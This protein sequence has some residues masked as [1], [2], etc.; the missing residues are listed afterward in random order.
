MSYA[1]VVLHEIGCKYH[2]TP[3]MMN[4]SMGRL[5]GIDAATFPPLVSFHPG[6]A[7]PRER[8]PKCAR[9]RNHGI[10]SWLKGH[11][12]HCKY[13]T[14]VCDKCKLIAERQRVMAA[15]VALK[16]KQAA[17]DAMALGLRMVAGQHIDHLPPG[18]VWDLPR[19]E[20]VM[21]NSE[22]DSASRAGSPQ[23]TANSEEAGGVPKDSS[24]GQS[25]NTVT[26]KKPGV[27][28]LSRFQPLELLT[29]LFPAEERRVLELVFECSGEEVLTAIEHLVCMRQFK[30]P[31][32]G[33]PN[34]PAASSTI[35]ASNFAI[36][37]LMEFSQKNSS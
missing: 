32:V 5:F 14:C 26:P 11:K 29:L 15:Q 10:V 12:R 1:F 7:E 35:K 19:N 8:K 18:P 20:T 2:I 21:S 33:S 9:C 3:F 6:M 13:K 17:E 22:S 16:R 27:H 4:L 23:A 36:G 34:V 28:A 30:Q 25:D 37:S 24:D 31:A